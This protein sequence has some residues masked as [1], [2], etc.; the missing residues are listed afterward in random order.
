MPK[1]PKSSRI[2]EIYKTTKTTSEF[3]AAVKAEGYD[4]RDIPSI[5]IRRA[6][7]RETAA[8]SRRERLKYV[9]KLEAVIER[10]D[11]VIKKQKAEIAAL[12]KRNICADTI[13]FMPFET[14]YDTAFPTQ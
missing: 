2:D 13:S 14:Y 1:I 4:P 7:N 5:M 6:K 8:R 11:I 10:Q 3:I 9:E 12:E